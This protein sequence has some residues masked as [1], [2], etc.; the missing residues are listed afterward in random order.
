M[1]KVDG[2]I[3]N[4]AQGVSQQSRRE[5][6]VGQCEAQENLSSTLADGLIRRGGTEYIASLLTGSGW[7][8]EDYDDDSEG[9]YIIAHRIGEIRVFNLDGTEIDVTVNDGASTYLLGNELQVA[10]VEDELYL[11][12]ATVETGM[13]EDTRTYAP[14]ASIVFMLGG[15]YGRNYKL[16]VNYTYDGVETTVV[17][18]Y[19]TPNGSTAAHIEDIAT[20]AIMSQLHTRL[21]E[22]LDTSYVADYNAV[23]AALPNYN[24]RLQP[25]LDC[26]GQPTNSGFGTPTACGLANAAFSSARASLLNALS[27]LEDELTPEGAHVQLQM[28]TI[29]SY[30][31]SLEPVPTTAVDEFNLAVAGYAALLDLT[32]LPNLFNIDLVDDVI[33]VSWIDP[34]QTGAITIS[35]EDGDGGINLLAVNG[36]VEDVGDLPRYAPSNYLVK[37]TESG[38]ATE[39]DWYLEFIP[40][41]NTYE[42]GDGFGKEGIWVE[43]V[44][45][46]VPFKINPATMPHVLEKTGDNTMTFKVG[47]WEPRNVGDLDSNPNPSFIGN[48]ITDIGSFQGRLEFLSGIN[49]ILSRTNKPKD[50]FKQSATANADSD[51]IDIASSLGN[52]KLLTAVEHNRDLIVFSDKAQFVLFGRAA[53]TPENSSLVLTTKYEADLRAEPT[54]AGKNI[55][56]AFRYGKFTGMQEFFTEGGEDVN[57]AGIITQHVLRYIAGT[58]LQLV[59]TTNFSKL[60]IRTDDD[61]STIYVY[62]YLW[63]DRTKVQASW[64]KWKFPF[65]IEHCFFVDNLL[66][67]VSSEGGNTNLYQLDLDRSATPGIGYRVCLDCRITADNIETAI[68]MPYDLATP[69]DVVVV[70]GVGCPHPGLLA[71][72]KSVSGRVITLEDSMNSGTVVVGIP[73]KSSFKPSSPFVRDRDGNKVPGALTIKQYTVHF[74]DT[75]FYDFTVTDEHGYSGTT[76]YNGRV[77]SA[78]SNRVG[79]PILRTGS[80]KHGYKK[81]VDKSQ[82]E[83]SSSSHLPFSLIELEWEGQWI[84]KGRHITGG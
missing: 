41:D 48:P 63:I 39:D 68:I 53:I 6:L 61:K 58:P 21:L 51:P 73:Y 76:S 75:G 14:N 3:S 32:D 36:S 27:A 80:Y 50:F 60:L 71:E 4:L 22:G 20:N 49:L 5:R 66:Y 77:L 30:V 28:D 54:P 15:Q 67:L 35:V 44:A 55:F 64:S 38:A 16:T 83:L 40:N 17:K 59:S 18:E 11:L 12:D 70:Q 9:N 33:S 45:P 31:N 78:P 26:I 1:A 82:L 81:N 62:E 79:Q 42:P 46:D 25:F 65:D 23:L 34:T 24:A 72:V 52:F 69:E 10:G 47:E 57:D 2:L 43:T 13:L 37:V 29:L 7:K 19:T 74:R 56:F 84:K 8:F